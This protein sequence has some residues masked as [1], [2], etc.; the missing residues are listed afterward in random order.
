MF[1]RYEAT[2][3]VPPNVKGPQEAAGLEA[4]GY[5]LIEHGPGSLEG[6]WS[7]RV[8]GDDD[9]LDAFAE[10]LK[11]SAHPS[12]VIAAHLADTAMT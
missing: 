11:G 10:G 8:A 5:V 1:R 7:I 2:V 12:A 3:L 6:W 9:S 4:S